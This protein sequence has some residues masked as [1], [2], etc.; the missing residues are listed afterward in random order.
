MEPVVRFLRA[1]RWARIGLSVACVVLF[2]GA[3][4]ML[5]YP[6]YTNIVTDRLQ[7]RL[8]RELASPKL[9]QTYRA[10]SLEV[11]DALTRIK[12]P[13][14]GVDTVVV[15]GTSASAL[16]AGAGHYPSTPLPCEQGNVGIAGHRT[17]YGKPFSNVDQLRAGDQIILTTPI[18]TCVYEV[19]GPPTI[20]R[21]DDWTVVANDPSTSTLT[22]TSCHPKGSARQRIVIKAKLAQGASSPA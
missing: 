22:L 2:V 6:F 4:G 14:I 18:G 12:I 19:S 3:V 20:H 21:P 16:K 17:T 10:K 5:A 7:Q 15:E 8:T 13:A 11:G 1:N 9:E